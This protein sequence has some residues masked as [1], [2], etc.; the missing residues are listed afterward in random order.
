MFSRRAAI[1]GLVTTLVGAPAILRDRY[2]VFA[3]S[4]TQYSSRAIRL[5]AEATVV[6]L[7][8]QFMFPHATTEHLPKLLQW[9]RQP[10]T[11]RAS[12]AATFSDSRIDVFCLGLGVSSDWGDASS[13]FAQW[14]GFIAAY[15]DRLLRIDDADDFERVK[16]ERKIGIMLTLQDSTHL[17][18]EA[19]VDHFFGLG[20]RISQ[21]TYNHNNGLGSGFLENRDGGLTVLGQSIMRRMESVGMAVDVSHCAD[22]TT[23]DVLDAAKKPVIITHAACRS[24]VGDHPRAKTDEMIQKMA[25]TG[26][27]MGIPFIRFLVRDREPVDMGH[28]LDHFDY[29]RKLVGTEFV[30]VG[31]DVDITGNADTQPLGPVKVALSNPSRQTPNWERYKEHRDPEDPRAGI[32]GLNHSKRMFDLTEGFISRGYSDSDIKLILGGNAVRVFGKIWSSL[33][34]N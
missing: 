23:L 5:M 10:G 21:L 18:N 13:F 6:D 22:Q 34:S 8:N 20:Q 1:S 14:N 12:D 9:L 24:V 11:F 17:K 3:Q 2:P 30:A 32:K 29:M 7:L 16:R 31:S 26:G 27:L 19:N 25:S 4:S 15:P 33:A 28:V